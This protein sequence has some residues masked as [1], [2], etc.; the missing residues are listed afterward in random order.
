MLLGCYPSRLLLLDFPLFYH[1]LLIVAIPLIA[2]LVDAF[3]A[4]N[5]ILFP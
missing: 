4:E 3:V 1:L 5:A 2:E